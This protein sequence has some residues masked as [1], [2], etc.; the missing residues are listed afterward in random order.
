V[1]GRGKFYEEAG[2][3]RDVVQNHM[4]QVVAALAM[5]QA[6]VKSHCLLCDERVA[7]LA[8]VRPLGVGDV[9]RGQYVGYRQ[10]PGVAAD[11]QVETFAAVRLAIDNDRWAGVPFYVRVGKRLPVT[12]TEVLIRFKRSGV[13]LNGGEPPV[14]NYYRFRLSPE[15]LIALGAR[16]KQPGEQMAGRPI[17]LI[18]HYEPPGEMDPYARLLSDA[19]RGDAT[20]FA[21]QDGVE[22][23]WRVVDGVLGNVT[24][25]FP[26]EPGT[27]GP[28]EAQTFA[29]PGGWHDPAVAEP[30][31]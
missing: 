9:V 4:L 11:S 1:A 5:E 17:E 19:A 12:A 13:S 29:P 10:E 23:S 28:A 31:R 20:L 2:A 21:R 18:A 16:V 14:P 27:W 25:V 8:R 26:Y 24:P 22:A 15:V 3:I 6:A 7:V 30:A